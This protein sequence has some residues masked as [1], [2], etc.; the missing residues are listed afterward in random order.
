MSTKPKEK[1][2]K[3]DAKAL[4]LQRQ[5]E[6]AR[7]RE[8]E[9]RKRQEELRKYEVITLPTGL[10]LILTQYCI[11]EAW[12]NPKPKDFFADFM[13]RFFK[14]SGIHENFESLE[15][16]ILAEFHLFNLI[17]AKHELFLDDLRAAVLLNLFWEILMHG[18][19]NYATSAEEK[20]GF[21]VEIAAVA[22]K[23]KGKKSSIMFK[24]KSFSSDFAYFQARLLQHAGKPDE[25]GK[26]LGIFD[27]SQSKL[28]AEF[29]LNSVF[30]HYKLY[31]NIFNNKQKNEEI[32]IKVHVD[33]PLF[34]DPLSRAL[35]MG[36]DRIE[37]KDEDEE[38]QREIEEKA[39]EMREI[40]RK[41]LEKLEENRE[42]MEFERS[43]RCKTM[44]LVEESLGNTREMWLKEVKE[45][46]TAVEKTAENLVNPKKK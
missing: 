11:N 19:N 34:V 39:R 20:P 35:F 18:N 2:K 3:T 22:D 5:A 16:N 15:V 21:P 28:I 33:C 7:R 30:S 6:E 13:G 9:E 1:P 37:I 32:L 43:E 23:S 41:Y 45:K 36:K 29:A 27:V 12:K 38:Y 26:S 8:E 44:R 31:E 40:Q 17:F 25:S 46:A 10:R 4:E 14:K 42:K 24:E